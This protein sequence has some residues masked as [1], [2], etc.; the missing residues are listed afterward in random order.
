MVDLWK[1]VK[2]YFYAP[3]TQG[4]NSIK[5]VLP[6]ILELSP[7]LQEVYSKPI[8][9]ANNGIKSL[10][11]KD[12]VWLQRDSAGKIID[13]YAQLPTLFDDLTDADIQFLSDNDGIRNGGAALTA[14]A[15]MQFT[16]MSIEERKALQQGLLKYC[17]LDTLA[18]VMIY[19]G[20]LDLIKRQ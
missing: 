15:K 9:G 16:Q 7:W 14:Y 18:M 11:F 17:E 6:A 13:P 5:Y 8:Y 20:W 3:Q 2:L 10:N 12:K 1:L 4:S 19:Q